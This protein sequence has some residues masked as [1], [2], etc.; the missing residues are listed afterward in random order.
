MPGD[1]VYTC[2][3]KIAFDGAKSTDGDGDALVYRWDF[4]DGAGTEES[5]EPSASHVDTAP[6][7]Y[8]VIVI[9]RD[10]TLVVSRNSSSPLTVVAG[11]PPAGYEFRVTPRF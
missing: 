8:A 10:E 3:S 6:G 5:A 9:A 1:E 4:G 2:D 11:N 7:H